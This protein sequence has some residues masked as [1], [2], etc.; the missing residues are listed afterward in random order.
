M[1]FVL[2]V[3]P[4]VFP[5]LEQGGG[6]GNLGIWVEYQQRTTPLLITPQLDTMFL[7]L[8]VL[9][10]KDQRT[11]IVMICWKWEGDACQDVYFL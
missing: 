8:I 9:S 7:N 6:G 1:G 3:F 11:F 4:F 5:D 2:H 10:L